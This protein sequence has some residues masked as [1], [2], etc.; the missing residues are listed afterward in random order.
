MSKPKT[1]PNNKIRRRPYMFVWGTPRLWCSLALPCLCISVATSPAGSTGTNG[2]S[3]VDAIFAQHCLDCHASK[4][5]EGQLVLESFESLMKGGELGAAIVPG[6][7]S[8]SLLV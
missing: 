4:D 2:Y 7:S 1:A 3:A 6:K 5:P 8:E